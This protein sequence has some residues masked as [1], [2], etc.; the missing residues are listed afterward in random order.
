MIVLSTI[1]ERGH[2]TPYGI[3]RSVAE[4]TVQLQTLIGRKELLF[5]RVAAIHHPFD[6]NCKRSVTVDGDH[7]N[8]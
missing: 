3:C 5:V 6:A 1:V 7:I 2:F 4:K 8:F